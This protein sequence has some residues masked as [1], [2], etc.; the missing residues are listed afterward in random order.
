MLRKKYSFNSKWPSLFFYLKI[1]Q[2]NSC[3]RRNNFQFEKDFDWNGEPQKEV[4]NK[5]RI[6]AQACLAG[7][8]PYN[9]FEGYPV[10]F[11]QHKYFDL[12]FYT[13][14]FER[15]APK[16]LVNAPGQ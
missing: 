16:G 15:G 6:E 5:N 9:F 3:L 2:Q 11:F 8:I 1:V 7:G 13:D 10:T 12:N 4:Y 14:N